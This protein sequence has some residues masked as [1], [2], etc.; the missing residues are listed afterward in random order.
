VARFESL[1]DKAVSLD[2]PPANGGLYQR[3]MGTISGATGILTEAG[4]FL[5]VFLDGLTRNEEISNDKILIPAYTQPFE[6]RNPGLIS[7]R[8]TVGLNEEALVVDQSPDLLPV[9]RLTR[10][11]GNMQGEPNQGELWVDIVDPTD[12]PF[13]IDTP[14]VHYTQVDKIS[15]RPF[16]TQ[17]TIAIKG[18]VGMTVSTE[19]A[20]YLDPEGLVPVV[21]HLTVPLNIT[22][23]VTAFSGWP[24]NGV[25]YA[26][27]N[28]FGGD[29]WA[30]V[31][32]FLK[33]VWDAVSCSIGWLL[34]GAKSLIDQLSSLIDY[35]IAQASK[36][37]ELIYNTIN[38]VFEILQ[39]AL[40]GV[41]SALMD[42]LD[43]I[44]KSLP[45][46]DFKLSGFGLGL[47]IAVNP[48][49]ANRLLVEATLGS[50]NM[51]ARFVNLEEAGLAARQDWA[52]WDILANVEGS[53]GPFTLEATIDPLMI[54]NDR[55]LRARAQWGEAFKLDFVMP[56]VETYHAYGG[57]V[58]IPIPV[59][60]IGELEIELGFRVRASERLEA[61]DI[62]G[63][64]SHS[65][66]EGVEQCGGTPTN[67]DLLGECTEQIVR[68]FFDDLVDAIEERLA[69]IIDVTLFVRGTL[70][71]EE[72]VGVGASLSLTVEGEGLME[73]FAFIADNIR[74]LL[75]C[76]F[77]NVC[78]MHTENTPVRIGEHIFVT[79]GIFASVQAP[80]FIP[81]VFPAGMNAE[82]DVTFEIGANLALLG[83]IVGLDL[84]E[85]E[86]GFGMVID[87][88][89]ISMAPGLIGADAE[90]ADLWVFK[91]TVTAP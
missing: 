16:Q 65:I 90:M 22:L 5:N 57:S 78:V 69:K 34:D 40:Q 60:P 62:L 73:I 68:H 72:V 74:G 70:I 42:A 58:A 41:V 75:D 26:S 80:T 27:S 67:L 1:Y 35:L 84:G 55:F 63:I 2:T 10:G 21:D 28:T 25:T 82:V 43:F 14:N 45:S 86:I 59:P 12:I 56:E 48:D 20:V 88:L 31:Q 39:K 64:I 8:S 29:L 11:G 91:G 9:T 7:E 89:P 3:M 85:W 81:F 23:I 87:N 17:W 77:D 33:G 50:F 37:I 52:S 36:I 19:R 76:L 71:F 61:I 83:K 6:F 4:N 46:F 24:L 38:K 30:K 49:V 47:R 13:S 54:V 32:S 44:L 51:T 18:S 79:F 53:I 15:D 66:Q